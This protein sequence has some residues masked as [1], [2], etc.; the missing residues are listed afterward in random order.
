MIDE[1][2][3]RSIWFSRLVARITRAPRSLLT[4]SGWV[5]EVDQ[6][7]KCD[8]RVHMCTRYIYIY[9]I[10]V[11]SVFS[12]VTTARIYPASMR[13]TQNSHSSQSVRTPSLARLFVVDLPPTSR[14]GSVNAVIKP[15]QWV[16][17]NTLCLVI[18]R[19]THH[20]PSLVGAQ[21]R[22]FTVLFQKNRFNNCIL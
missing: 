21:S 18:E 19:V 16:T 4:R 8:H 1:I 13:L 22:I 20:P 14:D 11:G 10:I 9:I 6:D 12:D 7:D 5:D 2:K 15:L 3:V 17:H